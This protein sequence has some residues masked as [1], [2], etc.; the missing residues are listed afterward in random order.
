MLATPSMEMTIVTTEIMTETV[1]TTDCSK[2][3]PGC[4]VE[5]LP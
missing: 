5:V 2:F 4:T 3:A 1:E